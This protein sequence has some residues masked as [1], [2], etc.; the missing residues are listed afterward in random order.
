MIKATLLAI[1]GSTIVLAHA[2]VFINKFTWF[3]QRHFS[4][5]LVIATRL[6]NQRK[7]FGETYQEKRKR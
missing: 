4:F 1:F 5:T 2:N 7:I 6:A 3:G